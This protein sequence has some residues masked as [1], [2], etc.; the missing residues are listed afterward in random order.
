MNVGTAFKASA[1]PAKLLEP[2]YRAFD[3]P[4]GFAQATT[5]LVLMFADDRFNPA[6]PELLTMPPRTVGS[7]PLQA[8]GSVT[9]WSGSAFGLGYG[10]CQWQQLR[11]I[12]SIGCS[13]L[14]GQGDALGF[15]DKMMLAA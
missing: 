3:N 4:A 13:Y 5:M 1:E 15:G 14:A 7:V 9:R 10:V 8:F 12:V 11:H 6:L 2:R